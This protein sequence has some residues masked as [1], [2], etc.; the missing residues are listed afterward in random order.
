MPLANKGKGKGRDGRRSRSRNTTPSSVISAGTGPVIPSVTPYLEVDTSKLHVPSHPQYGDILDRLDTKSGVPEPKHLETLVEQLRQLSEAA[1]ARAQV[2]DAAMRE[3]ADKRKAIADE[4]RERERID[5]ELELRKAK[6]KRDTEERSDGAGG[7]RAPK[8]KKRKERSEVLEEKLAHISDG[9]EV[10]VEGKTPD[11]AIAT[12]FQAGPQ[13][14]FS[15]TGAQYP[16]YR[17][18]NVFFPNV[19][20]I[21]LKG[22]LAIAVSS[23]HDSRTLPQLCQASC[24]KENPARAYVQMANLQYGR[25]QDQSVSVHKKRQTYKAGHALWLLELSFLPTFYITGH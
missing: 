9:V 17:F 18:R 20:I 10:K 1:E 15:A 12:A 22:G 16:F 13:T 8:P 7:K 25:F 4:E 14:I 6:A 24:Y 19:T 11:Y 23:H 3:L 5:H 2:C 21:C